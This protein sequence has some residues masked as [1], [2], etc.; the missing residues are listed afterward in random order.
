[1]RRKKCNGNSLGCLAVALGVIILLAMIL[2]AGFWW[3][4]L[5]V[6]LIVFGI[7]LSRC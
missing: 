4:V 5:G 3:F 7:W 1:M 6:G 2:P